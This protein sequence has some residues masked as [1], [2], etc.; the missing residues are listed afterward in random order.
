VPKSIQK[1]CQKL[2]PDAEVIT[3]N[4]DLNPIPGTNINLHF[5]STNR[6]VDPIY[7]AL[8]L[9]NG[10]MSIFLAS[11]GFSLS[12]AQKDAVGKCPPVELLIT[13]FN[14]YKLPAILGG[15]V[16]PGLKS[17][18]ALVECLNPK[19]VVA[20]HDEDKFARGLVSRFARIKRAP[21]SDELKSMD[22]LANRYLHIDHHERVVV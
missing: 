16:S 15:V 22:F 6:W 11:H 13:P 20:T 3:F 17:V 1:A 14:L 19:A 2:L 9:E 18:K 21:H 8:L 7:D 4:Q 5:L 12:E 10:F